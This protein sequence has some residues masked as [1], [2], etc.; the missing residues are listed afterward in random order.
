[1]EIT[2]L[3]PFQL[4]SLIELS[5]QVNPTYMLVKPNAAIDT[6]DVYEHWTKNNKETDDLVTMGLLSDVSS[7]Y[8]DAIEECARTTG[9]LVRVFKL[10]KIGEIM[11]ED[12][13]RP[14]HIN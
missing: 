14:T 4:E 10:T 12:Q 1:M 3:T 13:K 6:A 11:F 9:R 5:A 7:A 2:E 8:S